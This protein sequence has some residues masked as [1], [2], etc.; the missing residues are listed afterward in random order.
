MRNRSGLHAVP[1]LCVICATPSLFGQDTP[2]RRERLCDV[3]ATFVKG[4]AVISED[5]KSYAFVT[6]AHGGQRVVHSSADSGVFKACGLP[7]FAPVT[8]KVFFGAVRDGKVV[9]VAD[10]KVIPTTFA[11]WPGFVFS[12]EGSRW[13]A[14]GRAEA[15]SRTGDEIK[16]VQVVLVDG[17]EIGQSADISAPTFSQ[18]AKH[19]AWLS[20]PDEGPM[21]L[22]IDGKIAAK[23][24][25]PNVECS[26]LFRG[27]MPLQ[28]ST[29]YLCNGDLVSVVR[30]QNGWTVLRDAT[31]LASYMENVWGGGAYVRMI[32]EGF[33]KSSAL[34][35]GSIST[36]S[37]APKVAWWERPAGDEARWRVVVNGKALDDITCTDF[38][39]PSRPV[40]SHDGRRLAY[41]ANQSAKDADIRKVF[42]VVDGTKR[43][44]YTYV[45]GVQFSDTGEHI[46]Y[47]AL[48][49]S[50]NAAWRYY[51]DEKAYPLKYDMGYPPRLSPSGKNITWWAEREGK[52]MVAVNGEELE[53][54]GDVLWG[55]Q[56]DDVAVCEWVELHPDAIVRATVRHGQ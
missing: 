1:V 35:G 17:T 16:R 28:V 5:G 55:P 37:N 50:K 39:S 15:L 36:A 27:S 52:T 51:R 43:G 21:Q 47:V 29:R 10:G 22:V 25:T 19:V 44:P 38:W 33:E 23:Y 9:V 3:P 24:N 54:R 34:H 6:E 41:V 31:P 42:L 30:D 7:V 18:D 53:V 48:D 56:V 20:L 4:S 45:W 49:G 8:N 11:E 13:A 40:W 12:R 26:P 32:F 14:C 2:V 46:A